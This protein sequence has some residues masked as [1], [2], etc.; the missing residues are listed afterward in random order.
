M[1]NTVY[2]EGTGK[3]IKELETLIGQLEKAE[4]LKEAERKQHEEEIDRKREEARKDKKLELE[5]NQ[6]MLKKLREEQELEQKDIMFNNRM[7]E[8]NRRMVI[9]VIPLKYINVS[10]SEMEFQG[11]KIQLESLEET[12]KGLLGTNYTDRN[13]TKGYI[14]ETETAFLKIDQRTNSVIIKDLP[15]RVAEVRKILKDPIIGLDRPPMLVEI[16]VT[17]AMGNSGFTEELG[18]KLGG[19]RKD[20]KAVYGISSS[21]N[22]AQNLNELRR[23]ATT[24]TTTT[25]NGAVSNAETEAINSSFQTIDLLQ[26]VGALGLSSSMLYMGGKTMLNIQLN[27]MENEGL[28]KVLS[29]PRIMTLNNRE[30]TILSGNSV[31]I[32]VA[33]ADKMGLETIDTGIS[34]KTKPHIV[35]ENG[36]DVKDCDIL[37]DISI[38]KSSLGAV[39]REKIETSESK[40]NSNVMIKN[41][42]T[43]ILGGL[44]QYTKSD[45]TGGIPL[46]KDIPLIGL[47][48]Q[49]KNRIETLN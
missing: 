29:N 38:E 10:K 7:S 1:D 35:L 47:F 9:D 3:V 5:Q 23:T 4:E 49:T 30:A 22:I 16:E 37:L 48:F 19:S 13:N 46:L 15:E 26:P 11:Q 28:G 41:G 31:S 32:P 44:F 21:D 20:G 42:Q 17:I 33:T 36:E 8:L 25:S 6:A 2:I 39:S 24:Q 45:S 12:L 40:V 34:I 43:L 18:M 27:A 14:S